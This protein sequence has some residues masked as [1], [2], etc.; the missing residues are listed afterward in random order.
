MPPLY[1]LIM[2]FIKYTGFEDIAWYVP[3]PFDT[4]IVASIEY[5]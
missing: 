2:N 5:Q 4:N 1:Y 3:N